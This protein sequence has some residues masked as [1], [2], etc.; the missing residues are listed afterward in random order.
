MTKQRLAP[1]RVPAPSKGTINIC[2]IFFWAQLISSRCHHCHGT[3]NQPRLATR[4]NQTRTYGDLIV[5]LNNCF[6]RPPPRRIIP[7]KFILVPDMLSKTNTCI[8]RMHACFPHV[9]TGLYSEDP[10]EAAFADAAM[11][12]VIDM[13]FHLRPTVHEQD[14]TK[15][16]YSRSSNNRIY[17]FGLLRM[18]RTQG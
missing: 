15:K 2:L 6:L 10:I 16:V 8:L 17:F 1:G 12:A 3:G 7:P 4:R 5:W 13:H 9:R 18:S 11:E 14:P